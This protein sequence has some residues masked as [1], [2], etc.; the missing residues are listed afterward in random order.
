MIAIANSQ[1]SI[2]K[3]PIIDNYL[4]S[5]SFSSKSSPELVVLSQSKI[6]NISDRK[7]KLYFLNV[8]KDHDTLSLTAL[9][10]LGNYKEMAMKGQLF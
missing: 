2:F 7:E 3:F 8:T 5:E 6:K 1:S 4:K 9:N 10:L